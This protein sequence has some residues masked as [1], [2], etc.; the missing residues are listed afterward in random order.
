MWVMM[1]PEEEGIGSEEVSQ[2]GDAHPRLPRGYHRWRNLGII[3]RHCRQ[4]R[5]EEG[6]GFRIDR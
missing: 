2:D 6:Y 5:K 4:T 3:G 1:S